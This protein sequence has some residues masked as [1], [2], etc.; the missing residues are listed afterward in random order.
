MNVRATVTAWVIAVAVAGGIIVAQQAPLR[1]GLDLAGF[2]KT[3]RP[4][5]DLFRH[6]N[7]GWLAKTEIPPDRT[8][9]STFVEITAR[10]DA[11]LHALIEELAGNPNK[12]PGSTAQQIGDFYAAYHGR[13]TILQGLCAGLSRESARGVLAATG[14]NRR[15]RVV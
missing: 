15:A 10:V 9:Y 7:G 12:K 4:Q 6:V 2:D 8:F 14:K 3:V 13:P 11:H 5:D 1:S